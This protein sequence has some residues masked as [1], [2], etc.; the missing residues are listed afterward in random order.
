MPSQ[1]NITIKR[2]LLYPARAV[3]AFLPLVGYWLT[4]KFDVLPA[5][6]PPLGSFNK[7]GAPTLTAFIVVIGWIGPEIFKTGRSEETGRDLS[8]V[9]GFL[10]LATYIWLLTAFVTSITMPDGTTQYRTVGAKRSDE[11]DKKLP[12][13]SDGEI[14]EAVGLQDKDIERAWTPTSVHEVRFLL[15]INYLFVLAFLNLAI[16]L[17]LKKESAHLIAPL[18]PP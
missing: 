10:F 17:H 6:W 11:I 7:F 8:M 1:V 14:L 12:G 16:G 9:C 4:Q 2:I 18:P 15:A 5:L 3:I 13:K